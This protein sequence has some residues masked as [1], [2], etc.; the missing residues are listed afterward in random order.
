MKMIM[1]SH[2]MD[3]GIKIRFYDVKEFV[4]LEIDEKMSVM[5]FFIHADIIE[6][7]VENFE[8]E[9]WKKF[10]VSNGKEIFEIFVT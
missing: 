6:G 7:K 2:K 1:L 8:I 9:K 5:K 10:V 4:K 3:F